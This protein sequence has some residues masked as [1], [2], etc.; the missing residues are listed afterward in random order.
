MRPRVRLATYLIAA[1]AVAGTC[2]GSAWAS[3]RGPSATTGRPPSPTSYGNINF[4]G[5]FVN[6]GWWGEIEIDVDP[7]GRSVNAVNGIAPG[8][9]AD[10][11][12]G[13][14]LPGRDGATGATFSFFPRGGAPIRAD[15]AFSAAGRQSK[16]RVGPSPGTISVTGTFSGNVVR[17]RLK[18][19]TKSTFDTCTADAAFVAR[20]VSG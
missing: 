9:C 5:S 3:G 10:R 6:A 14:M 20:R 12:F 16:P 7:D 11:D 1:A 8:P 15:G 2:V 17:G 13:R 18:A 19:H 4:V